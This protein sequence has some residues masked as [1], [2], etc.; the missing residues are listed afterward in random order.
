MLNFKNQ[1][2]KVKLL[3]IGP[4]F[5]SFEFGFNL[6]SKFQNVIGYSSNLCFVWA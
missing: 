2:Q 1:K 5:L 3:P 6:V 4:Q